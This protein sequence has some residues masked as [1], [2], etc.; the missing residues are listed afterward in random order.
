MKRHITFFDNV[1][2]KSITV[3]GMFVEDGYMQGISMHVLY[4]NS[5]KFCYYYWKQYYREKVYKGFD[6]VTK[7]SITVKRYVYRK[8][9][10]AEHI[11][12]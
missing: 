11:H 6:N 7:S 12:A 5:K 8:W 4:V 1:T 3:K 10:H 2:E 9:L